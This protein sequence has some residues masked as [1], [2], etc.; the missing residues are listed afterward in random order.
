MDL[1]HLDF[2]LNNLKTLL[3][4]RGTTGTGA[5]FL[6]LF[7][8]D[9]EKVKA[10]EKMVAE[11]LGF[12]SA[13]PVSGADVHEKGGLFHPLRSLG[14]CPERDEVLRGYKASFS[15]QGGGRAL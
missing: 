15:S 3:G 2:T 14:H 8:G 4:C 1:E 10:L 12:E 6:E 13:Y 5:S 11:K 7:G 9:H